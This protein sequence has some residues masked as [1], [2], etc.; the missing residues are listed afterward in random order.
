MVLSTIIDILIVS[1]VLT[2]VVYLTVSVTIVMAGRSGGWTKPDENK[3]KETWTP[4]AFVA[5]VVY[6]FPMSL[7]SVTTF[8]ALSAL[9]LWTPL[10]Y[11]V[12][13]LM[14]VA[15]FLVM[16]KVKAK[17]YNLTCPIP[18]PKS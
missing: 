10:C 11:V 6:V 9:G 18:P 1:A 13:L 7:V 17:Q 3:N 8:V 16:G 12:A 2:L 14:F 4:K 5:A 15:V